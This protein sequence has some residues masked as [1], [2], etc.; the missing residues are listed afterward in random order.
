MHLM[1]NKKQ[2]E[3]KDFW[4]AIEVTMDIREPSRV[5]ENF[6]GHLSSVLTL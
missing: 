6:Y 2:N 4:H 1:F 3:P 5:L